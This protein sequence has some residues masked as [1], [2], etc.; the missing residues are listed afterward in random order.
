MG[1]ALDGSGDLFIDGDAD[2]VIREVNL[3]TG[4]IT[5]V[6]G[7]G[8]W[9]D[10]NGTS[11][12]SGDGGPATAA[13]LNDPEGLAVSSSGELYIAD[14]AGDV[15][16]GVNLKTGIISTIAGNGSMGDSGDGGPATAAEL[17][18]P[19]GLALDGSGHLFIADNVDSEIREVN[20]ETGIITTVAGNGTAFESG[21]GGPATAAELSSPT[22]LALD[23][24]GHLFIA[25]N[26]D[27]VIRQVN[28]SSTA[29]P[30]A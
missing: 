7:N 11:S 19:D 28:L 30:T 17:Y 14:F 2:G 6:A 22:W 16:R 24:S 27:S 26:A 29:T 20:L 8:T 25:D 12:D 5:T 21:D 1:I 15:V 3:N 13:E 4:I 23:G 18:S 9:N 10:G